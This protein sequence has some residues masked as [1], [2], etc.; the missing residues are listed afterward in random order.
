M[1]AK[2]IFVQTY[3]CTSNKADS[4]TMIG[5]L[6]QAGYE[7]TN[8][9][10]DADYVL[11]NSCA[12]KSATE[13][14]IIHRLNEL[15]K[16]NKKVIIAGCLTKVNPER[17]KK[18]VPNFAGMLDPRSVHKV[19]DIVKE[20]ENGKENIVQSSEIP[21]EKPALPRFSFFNKVIDIIK[22]SEGC[23]SKCV[24]CATKLARGDLYSY[25]PDI[26][27]DAI[28]QG[29]REGHNEF[30]LT[31]EDSSAYGRDID[32]NLAELL[33]S[34]ARIEGKF[35][36]RVG[37]MN[38]L[39]FK[40]IERGNLIEVYKSE[41]IFKFLHLCVQSGSNKILNIM[42]R[43]YKVEDFISYVEEFRREIPGLTLMTDIIVGH[44]GEEEE[45]F[46]QTVNLLKEVKP[47]AV[48]IS[49]FSTRLGTLAA[50]MNQI[51]SEI[52]NERSK[53]FHNLVRKISLENNQKWLGWEGEVIIDEEGK[54]FVEGRNFSYKPI[55][56][57]EKINLGKIID[58][59]I[60]DVKE[61]FL[62][63]NLQ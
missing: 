32:T 13:E 35:F 9:E 31:S 27:R 53:I 8:N 46:E 51:K 28:K 45:D 18:V 57:K 58:V 5:L 19:V 39:H 22:I 41:K 6:K 54:D 56:I 61:N 42:R 55:I 37:M 52:L 48:N 2:N 14:K 7:I 30:H 44:P 15:S 24:F 38:P 34:V 33:E 26:I 20:I 59:K 62:V 1:V 49:K 36:I 60:V 23:L 40:K 17:I 47:D 50:K 4:Q 11:V 43:G 25:R 10:N 21:A 3:G 16:V 12:V 63:G 29:L